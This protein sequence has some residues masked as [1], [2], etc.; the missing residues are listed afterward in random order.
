MLCKDAVVLYREERKLIEAGNELP[1][2]IIEK[3]STLLEGMDTV[4]GE[5][6]AFNQSGAFVSAEVRAAA[7]KTANLMMQFFAMDQDNERILLR[8]LFSKSTSLRAQPS[9]KD[10]GN[11]YLKTAGA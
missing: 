9:A 10:I 2:R 5:L 4:L 8:K 6:K 11:A 3:K 1:E 7:Q